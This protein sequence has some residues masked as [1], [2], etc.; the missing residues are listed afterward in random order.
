MTRPNAALSLPLE[1]RPADWRSDP[2]PESNP[3]ADSP[4]VPAAPSLAPERP[5]LS[6]D[7]AAMEAA[8]EEIFQCYHMNKVAIRS[9]GQ[10]DHH[11]A[12]LALM[13]SVHNMM[14]VSKLMH[15]RSIHLHLEVRGL[16]KKR[17]R[18]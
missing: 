12:V 9:I 11:G 1:E 7:L 5:V 16:L 15:R 3:A 14:R 6:F 18:K 8:N 17:E 10:A 4:P 2:A 13:L